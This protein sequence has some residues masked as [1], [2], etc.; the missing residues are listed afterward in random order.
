MRI[1]GGQFRGRKLNTPQSNLIRPA[2]DMVRQAVFNMLLQY[3][4]PDGATVLDGF[5]GTGSYGLEAISRGSLYCTFLEK[6]REALLLCKE[7]C[8]ILKVENETKIIRHDLQKPIQKPDNIAA[9]N[10]IFL[11]PPY[12]QNLLTTAIKNI[13]K[14]GWAS[15]N[16]IFVLEMSK[17]E[18]PDFYE[19]IIRGDKTYG[20]S[21]VVIAEYTG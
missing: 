11:D 16:S 10:L 2:S 15:G 12:Q 3:D 20:Q 19:L 7:N 8:A 5:S 18:T 21:R 13:A 14:G 17:K 4:L 1:T 9:A 6:N